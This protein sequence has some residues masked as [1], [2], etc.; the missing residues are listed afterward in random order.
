MI[1][2]NQTLKAHLRTHIGKKPSKFDYCVCETGSMEYTGYCTEHGPI[3]IESDSQVPPDS[4]NG[5]DK[6]YCRTTL[7]PGLM[8][9]TSDI[10]GT[11]LGVFAT[12]FFPAGTRFGAFDVKTESIQQMAHGSEYCWEN[13]KLS[14]FVDASD[15][16]VLNWMRFVKCA[17]YED[18]QCVTAYQHNGEM[19]YM[20][21]R[22][23]VAG[24][25]ILVY[26][27]DNYTRDLSIQ[28][29]KVG[30][31][32]NDCDIVT[33]IY[34]CQH[35]SLAFSKLSFLNSHLKKKHEGENIDNKGLDLTVNN[36]GH[37]YQLSNFHQQRRIHR[38]KKL[39][40]C[41]TCVC[42]TGSMEYTGYCTE[43][44]PIKIESDLQV[45][46][47]CINGEGTDCCRTTLPPGLM[48]KTSDI[49]GAGLGVFATRFFPAGTRFGAFDV[50]TESIQ[51][52]ALGS[53]YC[54]EDGRPSH[55]VDASDISVS[56][57]MR[58]VNCARYE[59]EQCVTACQHKGEMH[60]I[61]HRDIVAG[62]E[63]LVYYGD[64]YTRDLSIQVQRI[65]VV[66]NDCDIVTDIYQC[67]HCSLAFSKL[68]YL[69]SHLKK[70][71]EGVNIDNKGL[72]LTVN[73]SG[74]S[75]QLSNFHQQRRI[76][77]GKKLHKCETCGKYFARFC[78]IKIHLR[79]HLGEKPYKCNQ[80]CKCYTQ[81]TQ[82][83]RH[84]KI[85]T[86]EKVY[87]CD[88]C[89][90]C[91]M[92]HRYLKR[93]RRIHTGEKP[94]KCNICCKCFTQLGHLQQ[95]HRTH[96]K[97]K[98]YKCDKCG[99]SFTTLCEI[100]RHLRIHI[101]ELPYR[102]DICGKGFP[103]PGILKIHNRTHTGEKPYTCDKCG[104]CFASTRYLK[105]HNRTHLGEKP[106][107][108]DKCGKCFT[109]NSNLWIHRRL[110]IEEKPYKCDHCGKCYTQLGNLK[111]HHKTHSKAKQYKCDRCGKGFTTLCEITRH[112]RI[113][114]GELPYR[115]DICGKGFPKPSILKIHNRIHT[116]EKPYKCDNCVCET[117]SMEYTGYCT[118]HGPIKIES[119]SQVPPDCINGEDKDCCKTTLPPGLMIKTSDIPGAGLGV[120]ATRFFPAGTRFGAFDVKKES[121]EQM[122][123][124]SE[125]CWEDGRP[126][127]FVDASDSSVS[128]WMR[129][130]NCAR[131]DNEQC[132]TAYQHNGEMHYMALRDI[133]V[134][135]EI[136]VYYGNNYNRDLSIQVQR[137]GVVN[138]DF[139]SYLKYKHEME[140]PDIKG[141]DLTV[142][143]IEHSYQ[144]S[145]FHQQRRIRRGKKLHK[146]DTCGKYFADFY[147]IKL[148][149]KTHL[150]EKPYKCDQCC[151][152]Y[153]QISQLNKHLK[154]HT[155][156][157]IHKCDQCGKCF[158]TRDPI[159]RHLRNHLGEKPY[160]CDQ[161]GKCF[162]T[163]D[164]IQR[165]L[166]NHL[167][168]KPYK[169]DQ[170]GKCF[171]KLSS[172]KSH[173]KIHTGEKPFKCN[174]CCKCF[175]QLCHL[176]KHNRTHSE[177]K[178][179][180]CDK[181]GKGF[182]TLCE[183]T[184]HLR[185]HI[186][187]LPYKCDIC[188]KGYPQSGNLKIHNR[189]HTGE[190]PYKCDKCG[191][192]FT[193]TSCLRGHN[194]THS[195]EKPYKCD[196]CG[197]CFT[198]NSN[199]K[200]HQRVHTGEKP[201]KCDQCGKCFSQVGN[202]SKHLIMHLK[203]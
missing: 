173:R 134:G 146:C 74:H 82:L 72:D 154:V 157:N 3:K 158:A 14:H 145:N 172:L 112:L 16:S 11:G 8:I 48:I 195:G 32:N 138:N 47:D 156:E 66:N 137:I 60:Y 5:E 35:C 73:N 7:P 78:R 132:V 94:Y 200:I 144:L 108:C 64:N 129:F 84:L 122:A 118:E 169:C 20:A 119:D 43:H 28:V 148:H 133:D 55:F 105:E 131:Y 87:K 192:C 177:A 27:G 174:I 92:K 81:I 171:I 191:K 111:K 2:K 91:F 149:L 100:T 110:H 123:H 42:E 176:K 99:K 57:W 45:P 36:S 33:D 104:K 15:S 13:G 201:F 50:K 153:T 159:Q 37:S 56:N 76:H 188:G 197:K 96:S 190:K 162:P 98:R 193:S 53:E 101:G 49:P 9:K 29:Q 166:I 143:N 83:N 186:G 189:I 1:F 175:T 147:R 167:G 125:Y 160:K 107:K 130:V 85:H 77:R 40:K 70:K 116:G 196:T 10:P 150:G 187:E 61:A 135:T 140:I 141:L 179:Y 80:C 181:C 93:H 17:R 52:M 170:C 136:L 67:Q 22:D 21:H 203:V 6:D 90:K 62:T 151:K 79:T 97:A 19:Y 121:S 109:Q 180:K 86:D 4:I 127:H 155:G 126:S 185:I 68:S 89:G 103:R 114:I 75:Y 117:G 199:L 124:G 152:C 39:H 38:G 25:E 194:K 34:Q 31:V 46:P 120:F 24:S 41:E 183:I 71:H 161:C 30:V 168:E 198:Q 165:H 139:D 128:N 58:F 102:C 12:R 54:L 164:P 23:I 163:L 95:H 113:H 69:N 65:G 106:Y 184:R 18:E 142:D 202:F 88:H 182:N 44:G 178:R 115:C 59:D 51:Q 26:Y 63:I